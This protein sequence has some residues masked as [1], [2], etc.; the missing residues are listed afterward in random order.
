MKTITLLYLFIIITILSSCS[1]DKKVIWIQQ[2]GDINSKANGFSIASDNLGNV[3]TTGN[4]SGKLSFS[5]IQT[6]ES[7]D[8]DDCF[9]SKYDKNG[10]FQ[11]VKTISGNSDE[12]GNSI[13]VDNNQDII[14]VGNF[15][16]EIKID[17]TKIKAKGN[18]DVF[19]AKYNRL[20]VLIWFKVLGSYRMDDAHEVKVDSSNNIYLVGRLS[21]TIKV[22]NVILRSHGGIDGFIMKFTPEGRIIFGKTI[23]GNEDDD[24]DDISLDNNKI[25]ISGVVSDSVFYDSRLILSTGYLTQYFAKINNKGNLSWI[26]TYGEDSNHEIWDMNVDRLGSIYLTGYQRGEIS[27]NNIKYPTISNKD[28]SIYLVKFTE[29][30]NMEWFRNFSTNG[31]G[32]GHSIGIDEKDN[33]FLS[34]TFY[35]GIQINRKKYKTKGGSGNV[36]LKFN[37]KG[38]IIDKHILS[39][40]GSVD[41]WEI[42]ISKFDNNII[43]VGRFT[44]RLNNEIK[45]GDKKDVLVIKIKNE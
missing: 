24:I 4:F 1:A 45:T 15:Y 34:G 40:N 43:G 14:V 2:A 29:K 5:G 25:Y 19:I 37:Q 21:D 18:A 13:T 12:S 39:N 31:N 42:N 36:L 44:G 17:Q 16:E 35:K 8:D 22:D 9:I 41:L 26:K 38:K 30:G 3:Y 32:Y 27:I 28:Y 11:W 10:K 23:G 20:G 33:I 7:E 6:I